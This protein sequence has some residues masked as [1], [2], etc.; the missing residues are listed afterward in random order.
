MGPI[1]VILSSGSVNFILFDLAILPFYNSSF[2]FPKF[3]GIILSLVTFFS[4]ILA[5]GILTYSA[6]MD[7]GSTNFVL[8]SNHYFPLSETFLSLFPKC[9]ICQLPKP[10]RCHH[11]STCGKCHLKMDHH[12]IVIGKCVALRNQQPFYVSLHWATLNLFI[13][14]CILSLIISLSIIIKMIFAFMGKTNDFNNN[15]LISIFLSKDMYT[16]ARLVVLAFI[17]IV[18]FWMF[19]T[20]LSDTLDNVRHNSTT[21]E[22][23]FPNETGSNPYDVGEEEN[24]YQVFGEGIFR[25]WWP[26]VPEL[27]GFE[28]AT[29]EFTN[30]YNDSFHFINPENTPK[31][32]VHFQSISF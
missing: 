2:F 8:N 7:P 10:P 25:K 32:I 13:L 16:I 28:W 9:E 31:E 5:V 18:L 30:E 29:P 11:C 3:I 22:L 24:M 26:K 23:I 19:Y 17:V 15:S 21:I 12:C 6:Y 27:C 20:F 14:I 4:W 1:T